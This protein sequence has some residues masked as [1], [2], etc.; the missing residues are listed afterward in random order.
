MKWQDQGIVLSARRHGESSWILS[1][2]TQDHGRHVGLARIS[3]KNQ[4]LLQMGNLVQA[5][6]TARLPEHLGM[7]Q[8]EL[9]S[10]PLARIMADPLKLTGLTSV[11]HLLDHILAERLSYP[12]IYDSL[13]AF[14][15]GLWIKKENSHDQTQWLRSYVRF[16]LMLLEQLGYGLDLRTCA[17][18]GQ[19]ENLIYVSPK[20]GRAVCQESGAPYHDRLLRLP[21][22]LSDIAFGESDLQSPDLKDGLK[23]TGYFLGTHFFPKGLPESRFRLFASL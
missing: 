20:T 12:H 3:K 9:V 22:F 16:E 7:W 23:M 14:I 1:L 5:S 21:P 4:V 11:I 8:L 2:L 19:R 13:E 6:W 18:T 10:S 15:Q 17:A